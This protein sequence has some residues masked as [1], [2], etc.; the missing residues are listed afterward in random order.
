VGFLDEEHEILLGATDHEGA[1][2]CVHR[3]WR[4]AGR[5][6]SNASMLSSQNQ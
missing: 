5:S 4:G 6:M 1:N 3:W 2:R